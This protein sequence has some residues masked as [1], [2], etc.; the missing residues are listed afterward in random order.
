M[1]NRYTPPK[2]PFKTA[3]MDEAVKE[4]GPWIPVHAVRESCPVCK[5]K[6]ILH[7]AGC[8]VQ[9]TGCLC[10]LKKKIQQDMILSEQEEILAR[11]SKLWTPRGG[12]R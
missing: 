9:I 4:C 1:G 2:Q 3:N 11:E 6:V 7:C 10:T 12:R 5:R 8:M